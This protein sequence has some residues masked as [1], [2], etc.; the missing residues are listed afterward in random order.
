MLAPMEQMYEIGYLLTPLTTEEA[1][2]PTIDKLIK[3]AII[4]AGGAVK[5][6]QVP[7]STSLAYPLK[8]TVEHKSSTF[9]TAYFG[10]VIFTL[11]SDKIE[12]LATGW[13]KHPELIRFLVVVLPP[14][15]VEPHKPPVR[16]AAVT[17]TAAAEAP[18][19]KDKEGMTPE[20][21][22]KEIDSLLTQA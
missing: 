8:K 1:V 19:K 3:Q 6:E 2:A 14:V 15:A 9:T 22:D 12:A 17:E 13:K 11:P 21:M 5:T 7:V 4:A 10:A 18:V 20:A 16:R